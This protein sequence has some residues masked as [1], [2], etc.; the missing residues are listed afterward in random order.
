MKEPLSNPS[1]PLRKQSLPWLVILIFAV[2]IAAGAWWFTAQRA[3]TAAAAA[4]AA[5]KTGSFPVPVT[6]IKVAQKDVPIYLDGLGTVQAFNSVTIHSRVDGQLVHIAFTE[7]QDVKTGDLLAEID[8]APYKAS[9][10]QAMAKKAQDQAQLENARVDLKRYL[11]LLAKDSTTQQTYET[12]KALLAQLEAGVNADQAA[13]DSA[14]VNLDYTSIH[15]PIDG[16][17]GIRQI[18]QGNIIHSS[19]STG[20]VVI[21]QVKP[22]SIVFTLPETT[23]NKLLKNQGE[24]GYPVLALARDNTTTLATGTVSVIDNQIDTTTGT[25]KIKATFANDNLRLWPGEF[26][27]T[28][29]LLSRQVNSSVVPASVIQRGPDGPYAFVVKQDMSVKIQRIK[30]GQIDGGEALI[31]EGLQPGETVVVDGQYKLQEGSIVKPAEASGSG[32][33]GSSKGEKHKKAS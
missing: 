4:A 29:L 28:R 26:V 32:N 30:V 15:S 24:A 31:E 25:I 22:I 9:L 17:V 13:V 2:L 23:V 12:Q 18:D 10:D 20:L 8:P 11:D 6:T 16:R 1:Q 33:P 19:D 3:A 21:T 5:K 7:G 14:K 27:N